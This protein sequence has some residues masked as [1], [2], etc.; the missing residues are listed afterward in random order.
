MPAIKTTAKGNLMTTWRFDQGRL[1]YFQFDEIKAIA[2]ALATLDGIAKPRAP[3]PDLIRS[4]LNGVSRLPFAPNDYYV[5]R[6]YK[7]V[8]GCQL[9]A[10]EVGGKIYATELCKVLANSP[11]DVDV[12]DYLAHVTRNFYYPSPI[13]EG[14][15]TAGQQIFPIIAIVK[16]L[17][18]ENLTKSKYSI[19]LDEIAEYLIGNNVT[20]LEPISD[21]AKLK[22]TNHSLSGDEPR[23]L[24]EMIRFVSQFSFLKWNGPNLFL[25][26]SDKAELFEIEKSLAPGI[27]D[28]QPDAGNEILQMGSNFIGDS[29]GSLTIRQ[30]E[31][32][33]QEFTEGKKVRV[34][35]LRTE[36]SGQLKQFYFS[37]VTRPA[38]CH[39]CAADTAKRYPWA[40]HVIELH[41]LL[42]L[43]SPIR[44]E[45]GTTS[46]K[47]LVGL[48]PTCHRAT[49]KY[50]GGWLKDN[51]LKDFRNYVEAKAVYS[52]AK[53]KIVLA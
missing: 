5:W 1:D 46:L 47:D 31:S 15:T 25:E 50:Y 44:V 43:S 14:Y 18:S 51:G 28:R 38:V 42:P 49:H 30:V 48:C 2:R 4:T 45:S 9:L 26:V 24:R 12:D 20:G 35:H 6:N 13:F 27:Y 11:D 37:N 32:I 53:N 7:R 34:T 16:L 33:E 23:Q 22:K 3:Q 8:F 19:S 40:Q 17:I 10:T 39:M 41:H 29:L 52:E 36:R 21:F